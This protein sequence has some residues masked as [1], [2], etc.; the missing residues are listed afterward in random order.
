MGI[1]YD[2]D[3]SEADQEYEVWFQAYLKK[4]DEF[5]VLS[6]KT[7]LHVG[8]SQGDQAVSKTV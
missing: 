2:F 6:R 8:E 3:E 1:F 5:E 7:V 4:I